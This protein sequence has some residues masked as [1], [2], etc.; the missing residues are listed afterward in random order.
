MT[1][2]TRPGEYSCRHCGASVVWSEENPPWRDESGSMF[3][4][5]DAPPGVSRQFHDI[6]RRRTS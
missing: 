2:R 4:N 6:P 3:C 5:L 1:Q